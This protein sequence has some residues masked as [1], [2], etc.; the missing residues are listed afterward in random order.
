MPRYSETSAR[1]Y[2]LDLE[3]RYEERNGVRYRLGSAGSYILGCLVCGRGRMRMVLEEEGNCLGC[4]TPMVPITYDNMEV[5]NAA[6]VRSGRGELST[7]AERRAERLAEEELRPWSVPAVFG[8]TREKDYPLGFLRR[9]IISTPLLA[10][11]NL[12][13]AA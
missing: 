7:V 12:R 2:D 13:S 3:V 1:G 8:N 11:G 6:F 9:H 4:S 10:S 5:Y